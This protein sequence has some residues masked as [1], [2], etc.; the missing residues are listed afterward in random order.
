MSK[1]LIIVPMY[2]VENYIKKMLDSVQNQTFK[3]FRC[4]L[5]DDGS[6]DGTKNVVKPYLEDGRFEYYFQENGGPG[7]A[8][9]HG[10]DLMDS[11][12]YVY[13]P[14]SDD[15]LSL[16]LLEECV[17]IFEDRE[18]TDIVYFGFRVITR[19]GPAFAKK[20]TVTKK[21][22]LLLRGKKKAQFDGAGAWAYMIRSNLLRNNKIRFNTTLKMHEDYI[23]AYEVAEAAK[24]ICIIPSILYNWNNLREDSLTAIWCTQSGF[25][26]KD[27]FDQF[28][29]NWID[30]H[31]DSDIIDRI[32]AD[33]SSESSINVKFAWRPMQLLTKYKD[34]NIVHSCLK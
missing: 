7:K 19:F 2:N 20:V 24:E 18:D 8:R 10:L 4:I 22:P 25:L 34:Y 5:I 17:R 32:K 29:K 21:G 23:F 13:I 33:C 6:T 3:N 26:V 1:V 16:D 12:D 14:D 28:L 15:E 31:P 27:E 11:E 9:N 30:G